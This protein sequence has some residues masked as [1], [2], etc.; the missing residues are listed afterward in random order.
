MKQ[1]DKT[2]VAVFLSVINRMERYIFICKDHFDLTTAD[3]L[4]LFDTRQPKFYVQVLI[5]FELFPLLLCEFYREI[6]ILSWNNMP[7]YIY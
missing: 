4:M 1:T 2:S 5:G 7:D 3:R 6:A